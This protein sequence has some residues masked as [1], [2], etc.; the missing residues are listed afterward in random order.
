M[1]TVRGRHREGPGSG[2]YVERSRTAQRELAG[3]TDVIERHLLGGLCVELRRLVAR[4]S[5]SHG[6][7][8]STAASRR[9][10]RRRVQRRRVRRTA[11][12]ACPSPRNR[13]RTETSPAPGEVATPGSRYGDR[14]PAQSRPICVEDGHALLASERPGPST[15]THR[16]WSYLVIHMSRFANRGLGRVS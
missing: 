5:A 15:T 1:L 10:L 13:A 7:Q 9:G 8:I 16:R 6:P 4:S 11:S 3:A 14:Y 2:P 12:A